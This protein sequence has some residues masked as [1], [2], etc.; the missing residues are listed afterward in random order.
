MN[1][2]YINIPYGCWARSLKAINNNV[3]YW[4]CKNLALMA[5][6]HNRG[7]YRATV[8]GSDPSANCLSSWLRIGRFPEVCKKSGQTLLK[9]YSMSKRASIINSFI[10]EERSKLFVVLGPIGSHSAFCVQLV[11][12][13]IL[14]WMWAIGYPMNIIRNIF[15]FWS[16]HH[17]NPNKNPK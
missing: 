13:D 1:T 11:Y 14:F 10:S 8:S 9:A 5:S 16:K 3:P 12:M 15:N 17:Q 2:G 6:V 4:R 7:K